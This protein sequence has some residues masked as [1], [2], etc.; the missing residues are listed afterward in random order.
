[1]TPAELEYRYRNRMSLPPAERAE[2]ERL[3]AQMV[4]ERNAEWSGS[5]SS[6][7]PVDAAAV[8]IPE[9]PS[10]DRARSGLYANLPPIEEQGAAAAADSPGDRESYVNRRSRGLVR[11]GQP[12]VYPGAAT[13][14]E[15]ARAIAEA[16]YDNP[17][18][19]RSGDP[20]S[21]QVRA[22]IHRQNQIE[23]A[24]R[25][26]AL[27]TSLRGEP[28]VSG[29]DFRRQREAEEAAKEANAQRQWQEWTTGGSLERMAQYAPEEYEARWAAAADERRKSNAEERARA[30][31]AT[32]IDAETGR[33]RGQEYRDQRS[34]RER[35]VMKQQEPSQNVA[36]VRQLEGM[37]IDSTQF[38]DPLSSFDRA[39]A[40]AAKRRAMA[41]GT[42]GKDKEGKAIPVGG[43]MGAVHR[44]AQSRQNPLE[45]VGR[46]DINDG[47]RRTMQ[48][49]LA[50]GRGP[51][52][53]EVEAMGAQQFLEG[54]QQGLRQNIG[55]RNN[56]AA[57]RAAE[58]E[59]QRR[60]GEAAQNAAAGWYQTNVGRFG[61]WDTDKRERLVRWLQ[62]P[63]YGLSREE[64]EAVVAQ[65]PEPKPG[66]AERTAPP[67]GAGPARPA[68]T[69]SEPLPR[70]DYMP[71]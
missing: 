21:P 50:N 2:V 24:R 48:F 39:G 4:A 17:Q 65:F 30:N 68:T 27:Q 14:P 19:P 31:D 60:R 16:E 59:A 66:R 63:A 34:E 8:D 12:L 56:D 33:T 69:P 49:W 18:D 23:A 44:R 52:A 32:V 11:R 15:M 70:G 20:T 1:M 29:L 71:G 42:I 58:A 61:T 26:A 62:S 28:R 3:H 40:I 46:G 5:P 9:D 55:I 53:N 57:T 38:G 36:L 6:L 47:Q 35:R 45:Y 41:S 25:A 43:T 13:S 64:A 54:A 51:T 10:L 22:A 7:D 37:G 67:A